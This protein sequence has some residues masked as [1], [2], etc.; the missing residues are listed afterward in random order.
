MDQTQINL[1]KDSFARIEQSEHDYAKLFYDQ[2]FADTPSAAALFKTDPEM[3]RKKLKTTIALVVK[4]LERFD[5]LRD[6]VY[7]LGARHV[8][9]G[10][11]P[12]DFPDVADAL[13]K[14]FNKSIDDFTIEEEDAWI[15]ALNIIAGVMLEAWEKD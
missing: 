9:Y 13:I 6:T 7:D 3:Q 12:D 10:V 11:H 14:A 4:G 2:L 1:V 8:D 5:A 15:N